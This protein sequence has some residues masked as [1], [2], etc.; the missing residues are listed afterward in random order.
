MARLVLT[1]LALSLL[2]VAAVGTISYLRAR[3]S[4]KSQVFDRL[5][6]AEQLKADSVDRWIDEQRR[7]AVFVGG[8]LGG[9]LS[10]DAS[11]LG[12]AM[13]IVVNPRAAPAARARA[14]A[15]LEKGLQYIVGQTA[16]AQELLILDL[17]GR[18]VVSTLAEHEGRDFS[19]QRWFETG[20]SNTYVDPISLSAL[21]STPT[22]TVA[23]PLFDR[24]GQRVAVLAANLN[25]ERL[26]RIVLPAQGLGSTGQSYLVGT[27]SRFVHA[28]LR[29]GKFAG[30]ISSPGIAAALKQRDGRGLYTSYAG[31]PVIGVYRW[32]PEIGAAL[33]AEQSQHAAFAP[34]RRL[35]L[36]LAAIG[37]VVAALLGVG[38]YYRLAPHRAADSRD[39]RDR[40][41]RGRRRPDTRGAGD[42]ARRGRH[43]RSRVQCDDRAA[44]RDP[45]W[46]RAARRR[47]HRRAAPAE[48]R[49]RSAARDD[50]RGDAQARPRR[51]ASKSC[52]RVRA[53]CSGSS[54]ATSTF[55]IR[56]PTSSSAGCR[57]AS[58]RPRWVA[59]IAR[60]EGVAG[61]VWEQAA[62]VVIEDYDA[63]PG[64]VA[65]F[66]VGRI[67]ALVGVPIVSRDDV[68]GVLGVA[69]DRTEDRSFDAGEIERLQRFAQLASIALDNAR[70]YA[71]AHEAR[72][73]A[74]AA[75]T[76]K[77]TFLAAMSHE[78][79]TPMNAVIGMSGLL[80]A[81]RSRRRGARVR[82]DHPDE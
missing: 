31:V 54:T 71:T 14:R 63:W 41:R 72:A 5:Q 22:M 3:D 55:A 32:L 6:A 12:K 57:R 7:N 59:R 42:H 9:D 64:R 51:S 40:G 37:L 44:P 19:K 4:L 27:D 28:T 35:A 39:H 20:S 49:A 52:S 30:R 11:G 70:L 10:G 82:V 53:I 21:A 16:D 23:T 66:P 13:Q 46:A 65:N 58:S 81:T 18:V 25:L 50:A 61:R 48:R 68:I 17:D 60:G 38:I 56:T 45:G 79:R 29:T 1:F 43:A 77:S 26:D 74:D 36:T 78:I 62:P 80:L 8:L 76:A 69:R 75:N 47:A 33:V 15:S 24:S 67:R 73:L 2:M 34:A